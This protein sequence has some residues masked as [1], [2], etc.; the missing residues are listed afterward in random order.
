M[1]SR[2]IKIDIKKLVLFV[3]KRFW[4]VIICAELGFGAMYLNT[5]HNTVDT[6][7][8]FGTMY[9]NNGNPN[10]DQY[11]YISSSDMDASTKLVDTYL[12]IVKSNKVL[13]GVTEKL[14]DS[15]SGITS[16]FIACSI[17]AINNY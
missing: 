10:L 15:Y 4:L 16:G 13:S 2:A 1:N 9:V 17:C 8:A 14:S 12:V 7:T 6:Y 3:L 5:S 11:Q